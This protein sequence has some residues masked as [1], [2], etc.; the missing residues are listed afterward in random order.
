MLNGP[1]CRSQLKDATNPSSVAGL[2]QAREGT[3]DGYGSVRFLVEKTNQ[4]IYVETTLIVPPMQAHKGTLFV[5]PGLQ[6]GGANF[7]PIDN[8]V[9]QPVLTWGPSCAPGIQPPNY[10]SWWVSAQYVNTVGSFK[11]YTGCKGGRVMTV[12]PGDQLFMQFKLNGTIWTQTVTN[13]RT[14]RA[15][16][17]SI[18][19]LGQAQNYVYFIIEQYASTFVDDA[20]YLNSKWKFAQPSNQGCTLAFRGIK[21]FVSTPQLSTDRLSCSV[22]KIIQRAKENP[23]SSF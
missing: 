2:T 17:F 3:V 4:V 20:V 14:N 12:N 19:L 18:G 7:K 15:V 10:S 16:K 11:G 21:D 8:G 23:Q 6:P 5:W 9:L 1:H 22:V 13:L